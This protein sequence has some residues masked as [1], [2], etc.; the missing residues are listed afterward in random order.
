MHQTF[1]K[2]LGNKR[3]KSFLASSHPKQNAPENDRR[4][5]KA[6]GRVPINPKVAIRRKGDFLRSERL[7][8][9]LHKRVKCGKPLPGFDR[10]TVNKIPRREF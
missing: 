9:W 8:T 6:V 5:P 3:G 2:A 10:P 1:K 7:L 4:M